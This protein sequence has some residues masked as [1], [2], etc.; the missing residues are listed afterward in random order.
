MV[1]NYLS[2]WKELDGAGMYDFNL[3]HT[4]LKSIME[5]GVKIN[6]NF[7]SNWI[8]TSTGHLDPSSW[9]HF[10]WSRWNHKCGTHSNPY[11]FSSPETPQGTIPHQ[12]QLQK[13]VAPTALLYHLPMVGES[14]QKLSETCN[15]SAFHC[16]SPKL[17]S[18][19]YS[20]IPRPSR[21]DGPQWIFLQELH[22]KISA[23]KDRIWQL[24][25]KL[26]YLEACLSETVRP[27][28]GR[29]SS[30]GKKSRSAGKPYSYC[31]V[32]TVDFTQSYLQTTRLPVSSP[33]T[34]APLWKSITFSRTVC[35]KHPWTTQATLPLLFVPVLLV[36][37]LLPLT[38]MCTGASWG[39][40][41]FTMP[42][43]WALTHWINLSTIDSHCAEDLEEIPVLFH[44][45]ASCCITSSYQDYMGE[46]TPCITMLQWTG[47][48]RDSRSMGQAPL[49]GPSW[50]R[51]ECI[52]VSNILDTMYQVAKLVLRQSLPFLRYMPMRIS[53]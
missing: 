35:S 53:I 48:E 2:D 12:A 41:A 13:E 42:I 51:M 29:T 36:A 8:L 17:Y 1:S 16:P 6:E 52:K 25:C 28:A 15:S 24:Q 31:A 9:D 21:L 37:H 38:P 43:I 34:R 39:P 50:P 10:G 49:F 30:K 22:T 11:G 19:H 46:F 5:R 40:Q 7:C 23:T 3:T 27:Y 20:N 18:M 32:Q 26:L 4:M 45:G 33:S 47:S 14:A 44:S